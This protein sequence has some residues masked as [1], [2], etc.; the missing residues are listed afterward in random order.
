MYYYNA[1]QIERMKSEKGELRLR[2][3]ITSEVESKILYILEQFE[4]QIDQQKLTVIIGFE[5]KCT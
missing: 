3:T 4:P 2:P 1:N 5:T